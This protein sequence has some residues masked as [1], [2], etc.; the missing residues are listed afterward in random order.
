MQGSRGWALGLPGATLATDFFL[1]WLQIRAQGFGTWDPKLPHSLASHPKITPRG[2]LAW[3][4]SPAEP[5]Q[6]GGHQLMS[7]Q[8]ARYQDPWAPT[9]LSDHPTGAA[10]FTLPPPHLVREVP[11]QIPAHFAATRPGHAGIPPPKSVTPLHLPPLPLAAVLHG[12]LQFFPPRTNPAQRRVWL[13]LP[14]SPSASRH[15]SIS[16]LSV[17]SASW[18]TA[19]IPRGGDLI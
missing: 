14:R 5:Q 2:L 6:P 12:N 8:R 3:M 11:M 1:V 15:Q 7:L 9:H 17:T 18:K 10:A 19:S 4:Q 13:E 16:G